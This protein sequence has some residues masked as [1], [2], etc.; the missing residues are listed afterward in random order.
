[1]PTAEI[2]SVGQSSGSDVGMDFIHS[3]VRVG[4]SRERVYMNFKKINGCPAVALA[5]LIMA[6]CNTSGD[7]GAHRFEQK[8]STAET[9]LKSVF[10]VGNNWDGTADIFD[11]ETF[12]HLKKVDVVPDFS[13]RSREILESNDPN[14]KLF[15][16][17]I[18]KLLADGN[19]QLVDDLFTSHD[20]RY[21]YAS[22][23]SFRDIV[24]I[25]LQ[26][27]EL[28]WRTDCDGYRSDH[29]ALSP[30]GKTLLVS[31]STA[32]NVMA[33]DTQTGDVI[34]RFASG[35]S[36]HENS[37]VDDGKLVVHAN[38]GAVYRSFSF[39]VDWFELSST[40][41]AAGRFAPR[42]PTNLELESLIAEAKTG[43][44]SDFNEAEKKWLDLRIKEERFLHLVPVKEQA[45]GYSFG[46]PH[47][48]DMGMLLTEFLGGQHPV[49]W[50]IRPMAVATDEASIFFQVSFFHGFFEYELPS[51]SF[52]HGRVLN[53]WD[54]YIPEK[55]KALESW[56][57]QLNSA[58]HGL[59][60]SGDNE[61]LCVAGTMS[62]Y[63]AIVDRQKDADGNVVAS[64]FPLVYDDVKGEY[65]MDALRKDP[66]SAKPYWA[67]TS[68]DGKRCYVTVS[69]LDKVWVLNYGDRK[70]GIAPYV[71]A[72]LNVGHRAIADE[73]GAPFHLPSV[74][75]K[76][77]PTGVKTVELPDAA[78]FA[79]SRGG[80]RDASGKVSH[81]LSHPQRLRCGFLTTKVFEN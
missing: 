2:N 72:I 34:G 76:R 78:S 27:N 36:P 32:R 24:A 67:T 30:D 35:P 66:T 13:Q 63:V 81:R 60:I 12:E 20:G 58:H 5:A 9:R 8:K 64:Y 28:K 48:V 70:S 61:R 19:D 50:A 49:D 68:A 74:I 65:S 18:R 46:K 55:V 57:Y 1:M 17:M 69:Q 51:E 44:A 52:P 23:P 59:A 43:K 7:E 75:Y 4:I 22:R 40:K 29:A 31:C 25:D 54:L 39:F 16:G 6:S 41:P 45:D 14:S 38:I 56:Q 42:I 3:L 79:T 71:E 11:A 62:G 37:Y 80:H 21:L 10:V 26:S 47:R 77:T 33:I 15:Y 53:R 73:R